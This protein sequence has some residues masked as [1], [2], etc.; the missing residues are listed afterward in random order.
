MIRAIPARWSQL[1]RPV[2]TASAAVVVVC[3]LLVSCGKPQTVSTSPNRSSTAGASVITASAVDVQGLDQAFASY[4]ELPA[5]CP[6]EPAPGTMRLA[7]IDATSVSW[8]IS[9][10]QP[11][12]GCTAKVLGA[13]GQGEQTLPPDLVGPFG[14][15]PGPPVGVFERSKGGQWTMN[16]EKGFPFPCPALGGDA[17]GP[18]NGAIPKQVLAAWHLLPYA[19][20]C[21][22]V[23][24]PTQP[25]R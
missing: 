9:G 13:P 7:T 16:S 19:A 8:A 6:A 14:V 23:F 25:G 11:K 15:R 21:V 24:Y 3:G 4:E 12:P 17:P 1:V 18:G 10:F 2:L 5:T 22:T 20:N